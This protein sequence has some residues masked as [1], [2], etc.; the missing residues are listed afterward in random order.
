M[1]DSL[2]STPARRAI[3]PV[4]MTLYDADFQAFA[5]RLGS[6]FKRYGFAVIA[7]HGLDETVI[8]AALDDAKAFFALPTSPQTIGTAMHARE[9][10]AINSRN[11]F[12]A[13]QFHPE[14][15]AAAGSRFLQNFLAIPA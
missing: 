4:S 11:N 9:F 6:S 2:S 3:E 13:A 12:H 15:S 14:R 8:D 5:D 1:A 7:D 10:A